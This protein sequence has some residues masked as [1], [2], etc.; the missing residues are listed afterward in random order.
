[1]NKKGMILGMGVLGRNPTLYEIVPHNP[2]FKIKERNDF[3]LRDSTE[4]H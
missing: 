2:K 4:C 1:M 3:K